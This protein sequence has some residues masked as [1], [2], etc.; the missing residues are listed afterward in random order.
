ME[1]WE[2]QRF[3]SYLQQLQ[4]DQLVE[5]MGEVLEKLLTQFHAFYDDFIVEDGD[6]RA[7]KRA[8]YEQATSLYFTLGNALV[9]R[10]MVQRH[11]AGKQSTEKVDSSPEPKNQGEQ[12]VQQENKGEAMDGNMPKLVPIGHQQP[13]HAGASSDQH[14]GAAAMDV[15]LSGKE[16][17]IPYEQMVTI[18]K[19]ILGLP[20][21]NTVTESLIQEVILKSQLVYENA[22][23]KGFVLGNESKMVIAIIESKLDFQT[24]AMW[25]WELAESRQE[26]TI[27]MLVNFLLKRQR[28]IMPEERGAAAMHHNE[29]QGA[30]ALPPFR[31]EERR[32]A[33]MQY[34][35]VEDGNRAEPANYCAYCKGMHKMCKCKE[36][37]R[38]NLRG[39]WDILEHL[40]V[41]INCFSRTHLTGACQEGVCRKCNI[42]HNSLLCPHSWN[43]REPSNPN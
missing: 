34:R 41:C 40:P 13:D 8:E 5:P 3:E 23:A 10:L 36:F 30:A 43:N 16:Q 28:R 4:T 25:N 32:A 7:A 2:S 18:L 38:L 11:D 6:E 31:A 19:P 21:I 22:A 39:R 17:E 15:E 14:Q 29:E 37:K 26:P 35:P 9:L 42:K 24:R 1:K 12:S 33:L 27:D 20:T